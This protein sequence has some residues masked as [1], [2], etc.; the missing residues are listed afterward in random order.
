MNKMTKKGAKVV[1]VVFEYFA[2][3]AQKVE[4]AGS[5][6]EWNPAQTPLKKDRE[7][8]WKA[9]LTLTPG[10]YEYRYRIDGSWQNDQKPVEC[11]PNPYGTWNCVLEVR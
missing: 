6:N 1:K 3:Q 7:G 2:P 10:R 9:A 8:K 5:F 4:V 11:V